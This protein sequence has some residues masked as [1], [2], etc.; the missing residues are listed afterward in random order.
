M[1]FAISQNINYLTTLIE[2]KLLKFGFRCRCGRI[3]NPGCPG[4]KFQH[5]AQ[6]CGWK[7][8]FHLFK[9]VQTPSN[10]LHSKMSM[11]YLR[12]GCDHL[13]LFFLLLFHFSQ[14]E[15]QTKLSACCVKMCTSADTCGYS[16]THVHIS[17]KLKT[18]VIE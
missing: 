10:P 16:I 9:S 11:G 6:G 17:T 8:K 12:R 14:V 5:P 18:L 3:V 4:T 13:T 15:D 2:I 1:Y 7:W